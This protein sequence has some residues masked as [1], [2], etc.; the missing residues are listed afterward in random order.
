M[1]G[2]SPPLKIASPSPRDVDFSGSRK[3]CKEGEKNVP[4]ML[5]NSVLDL[6]V[7][8]F[9]CTFVVQRKGETP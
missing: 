5:G 3:R 4:K 1:Q 2:V 8:V 9:C 7:T 6:V